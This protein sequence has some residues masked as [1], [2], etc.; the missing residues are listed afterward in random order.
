MITVQD[1]QNA[2]TTNELDGLVNQAASERNCELDNSSTYAESA[3]WFAEEAPKAGNGEADME[4]LADIM[5]AA[6][7]R[8]H[9]LEAGDQNY[10][11]EVD[12]S[13]EESEEFVTWLNA[14]GH[15]ASLGDANRVNGVWVAADIEASETMNQLWGS[16]CNS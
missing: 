3:E 13:S 11:L 12:S 5:S 7:T 2:T 6:E 1:I 15:D 8:W 16:Y 9:E 4:E 10:T 14:Q